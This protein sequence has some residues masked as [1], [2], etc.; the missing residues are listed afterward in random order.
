MAENRYLKAQLTNAQEETGLA[1][2]ALNRYRSLVE[3]RKNRAAATSGKE[4][5]GGN[6]VDS[7]SSDALTVVT[8]KQGIESHCTRAIS[9][10]RNGCMM[11]RRSSIFDSKSYFSLQS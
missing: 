10:M 1:R 11:Q 7:K 6:S 2:A 4:A 3:K 9:F 8:P 5:G